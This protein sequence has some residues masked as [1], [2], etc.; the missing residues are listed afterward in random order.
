MADVHL[1]YWRLSITL[2]TLYDQ[3]TAPLDLSYECATVF[4]KRGPA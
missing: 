1:S 2:L 4:D 3:R